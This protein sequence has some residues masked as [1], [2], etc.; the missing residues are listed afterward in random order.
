MTQEYRI[1]SRDKRTSKNGKKFVL[2]STD[3]GNLFCWN[4]SEYIYDKCVPRSKVK[5]KTLDRNGFV[6]V[7]GNKIIVTE[8]P[9]EEKKIEN[10]DNKAINNFILQQNRYE[11]LKHIRDKPNIDVNDVNR[12]C[13]ETLEEYNDYDYIKTLLGLKDIEVLDT[14]KIILKTEY[15]G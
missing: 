13:K 1:I 8:D 5:V 9:P 4:D 6:N 2:I 7:V 12:Y 10:N 11:V 3:K 15:Y 14:S